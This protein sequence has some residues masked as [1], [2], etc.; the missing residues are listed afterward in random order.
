MC[1]L[2]SSGLRDHY[3]VIQTLD[4]RFGVADEQALLKTYQDNWITT[5]D[6][7]H[8]KALGMNYV[9]LPFWWAN[10]ETLD[11]KWRA[12]AFDQMDWLVAN[13]WKRGLYTLIDLHGVPG[14]Q[15]TSQDTGQENQ[16]QYW[17]ST[18]CQSQTA[19]IWSKVAAH[20]RDNPAVLGYDLI[21][22]PIGAPTQAALWQAYDSL[23]HTVRAVDPAHIILMEGVAW[24]WSGRAAVKLAMGCPAATGKI[25]LDQ[26]GL[27]NARLSRRRLVGGQ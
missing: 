8:I 27:R 26:C 11:G 17:S 6:L 20:F 7:D 25:W 1:P 12:D 5:N 13:A 14:G 2:D 16:N 19:A 22:E 18:A 15:S 3:S 9:R 21:N 10:V 24:N 4:N 23:Y